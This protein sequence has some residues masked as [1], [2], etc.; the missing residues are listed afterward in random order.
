MAL[1]Q[2]SVQAGGN[3]LGQNTCSTRVGAEMLQLPTRI[4]SSPPYKVE[5]YL[6]SVGCLARRERKKE[7]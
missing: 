7:S 3:S 4:K 5:L 6:L 2:H 1:G